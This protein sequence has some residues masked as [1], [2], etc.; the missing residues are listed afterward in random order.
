MIKLLSRANYLSMLWKNGLGITQEIYL[1]KDLFR[2]SM[3]S[4]LNSGPFSLFPGFERSLTLL[5]GESIYLSHDMGAEFNLK[6][7]S[8]YQFAGEQATLSIVKK[9]GLDFNVFWKRD[10]VQVEVRLQTAEELSKIK[11]H[12]GESIFIFS[13]E[14]DLKVRTE[15]Q[16]FQL[17]KYDTLFCQKESELISL[18]GK[19][20]SQKIILVRKT[21]L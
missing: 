4:I 10:V 16:S 8:P 2:L 13:L 21:I 9:A 12:L 7:L 19:E 1:E 17:N 20:L 6:M 5:E 11:T 15:K 18:M 3:A 14:D